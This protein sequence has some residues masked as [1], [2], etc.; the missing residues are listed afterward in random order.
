MQ[1]EVIFK[2][3]KFVKK[4]DFFYFLPSAPGDSIAIHCTYEIQHKKDCSEKQ[5]KLI[6]TQQSV[7]FM[8]NMKRAHNRV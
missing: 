5:K 4:I 6:M 1:V 3:M 8:G 2:M 7:I